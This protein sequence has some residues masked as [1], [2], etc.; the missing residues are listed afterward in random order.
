[1]IRGGR[2]CNASEATSS[3]NARISS[4]NRTR[5]DA[6]RSAAYTAPRNTW[7]AEALL[8]SFA[9]IRHIERSKAT[10]ICGHDDGQWQTLNKGQDAYE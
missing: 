3:A 5:S 1:M 2:R 7:N 6:A 9:E 4:L 8:K 10:V